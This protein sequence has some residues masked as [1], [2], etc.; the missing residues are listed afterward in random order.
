MSDIDTQIA[1]IEKE[2]EQKK[3]D[4]NRYQEQVKQLEVEIEKLGNK[5]KT[6]SQAGR[7]DNETKK[8]IAKDRITKRKQIDS[9]KK[10]INEVKKQITNRQTDLNNLKP[11]PTIPIPTEKIEK[12]DD[13]FSRLY[14]TSGIV[15]DEATERDLEELMRSPLADTKAITPDLIEEKENETLEEVVKQQQKNLYEREKA[16]EDKTGKKYNPLVIDDDEYVSLSEP[17]DPKPSVSFSKTTRKT[18]TPPIEIDSTPTT[19]K[20]KTK[21]NRPTPE[22]IELDDLSR[23]RETPEQV[24][25]KNVKIKDE[26]FQDFKKDLTPTPQQVPLKDEYVEIDEKTGFS[27]TLVKPSVKA[28]ETPNLDK[29]VCK[30]IFENGLKVNKS[31][32][33]P[34]EFP[35]LTRIKP[36]TVSNKKGGKRKTR[37]NT[38]IKNKVKRIR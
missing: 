11:A 23:I 15:S 29:N 2:I 5:F 38:K 9:Y 3:T 19:E 6:L 26:Y 32:F 35:K 4:L 10:M 17:L 16:Y 34:S 1:Q 25:L 36:I 24:P 31:H 14:D 33:F 28:K 21:K 13:P 18:P 27:E 8:D 7:L 20:N 30:N 22:G 12:S 37:K